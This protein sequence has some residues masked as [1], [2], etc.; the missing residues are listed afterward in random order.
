MPPGA[1]PGA[2]GG[3]GQPP[4]QQGYGGN[5]YG[6]G[7]P[8]APP[9][10]AVSWGGYEFSEAENTVIGKTAGRAKLWGIISIVV[11]SLYTMS[12]CGAFASPSFLTNLPSGVIGIVVGI[13]FVGVG[14][15]LQNVV[16]TQ[17]NDIQH[18]MEALQKMGTAFLVQIIT[19]LIGVGLA[20][21]LIMLLVFVFAAAAASQ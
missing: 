4:P 12:T 11:G 5:P 14:N 1:P 10:P 13:F 21:L 15:S 19:T 7:A 18:I 9:G 17:G 2:P 20:I 16:T 3:Y 8:G 6:A